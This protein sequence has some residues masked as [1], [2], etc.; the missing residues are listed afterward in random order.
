MS[1]PA[2]AP[3]QMGDLARMFARRKVLL[4]TPWVI[5]TGLGVTAAL[6]LPPVYSSNVTMLLER[7]QSMGGSLGGM[8]S[9]FDPERRCR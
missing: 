7:P 3:V 1:E 2:S 9:A 5:A 4:L 6:L 8:I